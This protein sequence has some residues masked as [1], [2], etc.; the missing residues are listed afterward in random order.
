MMHEEMFI[1]GLLIGIIIGAILVV[2]FC[3]AA[4]CNFRER[5]TK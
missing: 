2:G 5:E 4:G 3:Y 1:I